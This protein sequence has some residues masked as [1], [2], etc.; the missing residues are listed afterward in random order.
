[1]ATG[2]RLVGDVRCARQVVWASEVFHR[3]VAVVPFLRL[4]TD[5][6]MQ[7]LLVFHRLA[8]FQ[9][10]VVVSFLFYGSA[11]LR[12]EFIRESVVR[13]VR[14]A[15]RACLAGLNGSHRGNGTSVPIR[16]FRRE[17]GAFR[18]VAVLLSR[19]LVASDLRRQFVVFVGRG[20]RPLPQLFANALCGAL[21]A[22]EGEDFEEDDPMR[23]F[24]FDRHVIRCSVRTFKHVVLFNIRVRVWGQVFCPVFF[25]LLRDR[26]AGRILFP[27][28]VDFG[29]E[30]R[31]AL[32][33]TAKAT[34]RVV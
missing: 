3:V 25:R 20:R 34:R 26:A 16:H 14:I 4:P 13:V 9:F 1:M 32:T 28:G 10:R 30:C 23:R 8:G 21:R 29:D 27:L 17:V 18:Y 19:L 22:R 6:F 2:L 31:R 7:R 5:V 11:R 15:G 12:V 24:P 33:G